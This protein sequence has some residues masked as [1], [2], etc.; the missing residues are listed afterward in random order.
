MS[1]E[2]LK[3]LK[4][5]KEGR[6][7]MEEAEAL[8]DALAESSGEGASEPDGPTLH[9]ATG[10]SSD[11]APRGD[12]AGKQADEG[13]HA[14]G[15]KAPGGWL[16]SLMNLDPQFFQTGFRDAM[17][18]FEQYLKSAFSDLK[19]GDLPQGMKQFFGKESAEETRRLVISSAG[20]TRLR[21]TNRWG[22]VRLS[23]TEGNEI[24]V[25]AA[26]S[27]WGADA[28][29]AATIAQSVALSHYRQEETIVLQTDLPQ[30]GHMRFK[31]DFEIELPRAL[32]VDMRS[33][34]GDIALSS[35]SGGAQAVNLSGNI[36]IQDSS[37]SLR[38]ESKSGDIDLMRTEGEVRARTV[39]GDVNLEQIRSVSLDARTVSGNLSCDITPQEGSEIKLESVSGDLRILLPGNSSCEI[40]V[41]T[42]SGEIRCELPAEL[43]EK[44]ART[45]KA[46]LGGSEARLEARTKSGDIL[47]RDR[48]S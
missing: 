10:W 28:N 6:I 31:V 1:E 48:R 8:L 33:M 44:S 41:E 37:G 39:S 23:G 5:L 17:K 14:R 21:L 15:P 42:A 12:E 2:R 47:L 25:T 32:A 13:S 24:L 18:E 35:L 20:A 36:I 30:S 43:K 38:V 9:R 4:L 34:S 11:R 26:I 19:Q 16:D 7:T 45:L 29:D 27:A 3:I 22:D 40:E 46:S